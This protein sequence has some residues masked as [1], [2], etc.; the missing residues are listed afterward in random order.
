MQPADLIA[1]RQ[2]LGLTQ[3][4]LAQRLGKTKQTIGAW[5]AGRTPIDPMLSLAIE[6]IEARIKDDERLA[7]ARF[8]DAA[9]RYAT[10]FANLNHHDMAYIW[11]NE[12]AP[13][14]HAATGEDLA[15]M[16]KQLH[17]AVLAASRPLRV[18]EVALRNK[19]HL[20]NARNIAV[21]VNKVGIDEIIQTIG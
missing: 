3:E 19:G 15:G 16:H 6:G 2:R 13:R 20:I 1:A 4:G 8:N 11:V 12:L 10:A 5:E 21:G 18:Y 9:Q 17:D 7:I 14:I